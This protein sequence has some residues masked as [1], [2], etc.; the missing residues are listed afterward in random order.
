MYTLEHAS[1][2]KILGICVHMYT[3][4]HT[5]TVCFH[6]VSH[7]LFILLFDVLDSLVL[8]SA[9]VG[10]FILCASVCLMVV[11]MLAVT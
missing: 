9:A 10:L 6:S 5:H 7:R 8:L 11:L 2:R 1:H 4:I 3:H